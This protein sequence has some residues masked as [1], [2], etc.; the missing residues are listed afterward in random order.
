M[1]EMRMGQTLT[2]IDIRAT[3]KDANNERRRNACASCLYCKHRKGHNKTI[4]YKG[5][6]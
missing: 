6:E 5:G 2:P 4:N 3:S 1:K